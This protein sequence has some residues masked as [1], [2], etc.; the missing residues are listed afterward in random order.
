LSE[1]EKFVPVTNRYEFIPKIG[2][3]F[4]IDHTVGKTA[5]NSAEYVLSVVAIIE[6]T[7][8]NVRIKI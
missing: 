1:F 6:I 8:K 7:P 5:Q 3:W 2:D 4:E